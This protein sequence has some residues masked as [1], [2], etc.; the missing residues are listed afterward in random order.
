MSD[1]FESFVLYTAS[2]KAANGGH[3]YATE[4]KGSLCGIEKRFP[5]L[6]SEVGVNEFLPWLKLNKPFIC[7]RC[8]KIY[9]KIQP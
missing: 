8:L 3:I 7:K 2:E 4:R 1:N 6:D 9:R 5:Q